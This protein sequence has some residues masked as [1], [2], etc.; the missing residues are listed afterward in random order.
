MKIQEFLQQNKTELWNKL[1]EHDKL[2]SDDV[3][4]GYLTIDDLD[5]T[6]NGYYEGIY[7]LIET[8]NI[9]SV[10]EGMDLSFDRKYVKAES[11]YDADEFEIEVNGKAIYGLRYNV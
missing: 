2:S 5:C 10:M 8:D 9:C 7:T 1:I 4:D 6:N 3:R 11:I